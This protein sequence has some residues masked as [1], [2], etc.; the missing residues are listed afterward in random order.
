MTLNKSQIAD[1]ITHLKY[2]FIFQLIFVIF[3]ILLSSMG[4]FFHF[5][6]DHEISIVESWL[7]HNQ[8]EIL[9]L[10]K[11]ISLFLINKWFKLRLYQFK[12]FSTLLKES[13]SWPDS[14]A[15]VVAVFMLIGL[16]TLNRPSFVDH[17][18]GHWYY[19]LVS[20]FGISFFLGIEFVLMGYLEDIL[21]F[22]S[23]P[24]KIHLGLSYGILFA[25]AFKLS[26]PDYYGMMGYI[27]LC[28]WALI[29]LSGD[30]FKNWSNVF[31][32]LILFVAPMASLFGL[33]PIW[34]DDFSP[35]KLGR[36]PNFAFL[37]VIWMISFFYYSY[38]ERIILLARKL[39]R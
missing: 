18:A 24:S 27:L 15:I 13:F 7:H 5:L 20:F 19:L 3:V 31:C 38:R 16:I 28:Y 21:N 10:S 39:V 34:G 11:L 32:F 26:V 8:W 14:K 17:N 1:L 37:A 23:R 29:F 33:D 22:K 6:L 9:I 12:N 2:Y 30:N 35:F 25:I 36:K 4:A